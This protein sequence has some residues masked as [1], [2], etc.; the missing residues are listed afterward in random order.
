M[1]LLIVILVESIKGLGLPLNNLIKL[2]SKELSLELTIL[3]SD[4][5]FWAKEEMVNTCINK[6]NSALLSILR[7]YNIFLA[8]L[9]KDATGIFKYLPMGLPSL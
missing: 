3:C 9:F 5:L 4:L 6:T 1:D 2:I 8:L 7:S